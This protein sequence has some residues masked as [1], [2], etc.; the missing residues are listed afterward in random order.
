MVHWVTD[1]YRNTS[2]L[3]IIIKRL[4]ISVTQNRILGS[5][6][7][8][9]AVTS[10]LYIY[11]PKKRLGDVRHSRYLLS[12]RSSCMQLH[13]GAMFYTLLAIFSHDIIC[14]NFIL[15]P[16]KHK[17]IP[18]DKKIFSTFAERFLNFLLYFL[19]DTKATVT[20][21]VVLKFSYWEVSF[22]G[23]YIGLTCFW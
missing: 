3:N 20:H 23:W 13:S 18:N 7:F 6:Q 5:S 22:T 11:D 17:R 21:G 16:S 9:S 12:T 1:E 2:I 4:Y 14:N 15:C 19:N 8:L 10:L